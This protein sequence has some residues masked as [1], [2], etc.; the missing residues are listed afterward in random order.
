MVPALS[1][2]GGVDIGRLDLSLDWRVTAVAIV[3]TMATLLIAATL[4]ITRATR[5]RLAG[6][7]VGMSSSTSLASQRVRQG[8]LALQVCATIIVLVSAGLFV[9][10]VVHGFGTAPGF[11]A[12]Q[13]VF[14]SIQEGS[15]W[16]GTSGYDPNRITTRSARLMEA[17]REV[18]GVIDVAQ[19]LAPIGPAERFVIKRLK[20]QEREHDVAVT[21][22]R[23]SPEMLAVL[24]VPILNGRSLTA[25]DGAASPFPAVI[26]QS[27]ARR[28]WP[29]GTR[30][31]S[32]CELLYRDLAPLLSSASPGTFLSDPCRIQATG[33]W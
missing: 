20:A 5:G 33:P 12:D 13:T 15:P 30:W 29:D 24:G 7:L 18:P 31:A 11:D 14:V 28:L 25:A 4:P 32:R 23:G 8:L 2:P 27:L 10:A 17:L 22:L 26:T 21:Q 1:L 9:R 19:G 16:A 3:A 6:E